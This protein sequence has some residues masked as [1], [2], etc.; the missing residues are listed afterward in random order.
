TSSSTSSLTSTSTSSSASSTA[1]S[2]PGWISLGC[3]TDQNS[4]RTLSGA[5][6]SSTVTMTYDTCKAYCLG[7]GYNYAGVEYGSQ[8]YCGN[9]LN[10]P[11]KLAAS[12]TSCNKACASDPSN[13]CGGTWTL[14]VFYYN[15]VAGSSATA[16]T[17][18]VG[19]SPVGC[20]TDQNSPRTLSG[21][22]Y[23]N[24][25]TMTPAVCQAY[26]LDK[27]YF[28]AGVEYGSQCYCGSTLNPPGKLL[29]TPATSCNKPCAG[30]SSLMCGGTWTLTT[31]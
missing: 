18:P 11:G 24:T 10:S 23:S 17:L 27:G 8:C 7:K 31:F 25:V 19:W 15:G 6:Y 16:S 29:A 22:S 3:Y 13:Y 2:S 26:C 14:T 28:Y 1:S 4:P 21:A 5:S 20:Y 30:N 9:A 12:Q